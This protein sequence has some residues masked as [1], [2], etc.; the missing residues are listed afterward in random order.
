MILELEN[1]SVDPIKWEI[2]CLDR[3]N[4][5]AHNAFSLNIHKGTLR[6]EEKIEIKALFNPICEGI[7]T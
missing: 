3:G 2:D 6:C 7:F 4:P 5:E 1:L